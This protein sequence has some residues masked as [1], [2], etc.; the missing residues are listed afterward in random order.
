VGVPEI[1]PFEV[2]KESPV[3]RGWEMDQ[4]VTVPPVIVGVA[5]VMPVPLVKVN[6]LGL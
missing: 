5:V 6:E 1:E 2:E 3:G 4:E